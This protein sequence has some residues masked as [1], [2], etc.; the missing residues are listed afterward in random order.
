MSPNIFKNEYVKISNFKVKDEYNDILEIKKLNMKPKS[1]SKKEMDYKKK[2][3]LKNKL[4][5][6]IKIKNKRK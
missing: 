1:P 3:N 4:A 2:R 5:K 6:K